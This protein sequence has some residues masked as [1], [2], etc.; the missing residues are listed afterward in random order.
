MSKV[1]YEH[2]GKFRE[3]VFSVEQ[4]GNY[5]DGLEW[6]LFHDQVWAASDLTDVDAVAV[7]GLRQCVVTLR[8]WADELDAVQAKLTAKQDAK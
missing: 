5:H 7:E 8:R 6:N 3:Y 2:A 4:S 1:V